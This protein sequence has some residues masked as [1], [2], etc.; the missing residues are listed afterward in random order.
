MATY[1]RMP[2]K[3]FFS[4]L[5]NFPFVLRLKLGNKCILQGLCKNTVVPIGAGIE[6]L[7]SAVSGIRELILVN[8][9]TD[10]RVIFIE[11]CQPVIHVGTFLIGDSLNALFVNRTIRISGNNNRV[12][13][14]LQHC[15]QMEQNFQID[16]LF[17]YAIH[18]GASAIHPA[19]SGI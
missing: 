12:A 1:W 4:A 15:P 5:F 14:H 13:F 18:G 16:A 11:Q 9:N 3:Q 7:C 17:G 2:E 8:G 6:H 19:V 10:R